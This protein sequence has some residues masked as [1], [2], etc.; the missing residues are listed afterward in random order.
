MEH[1]GHVG[2]DVLDVDVGLKIL[3]VDVGEPAA[4]PPPGGAGLGTP[5]G[6]IRLERERV[7]FIFRSSLSGWLNNLPLTSSSEYSQRSIEETIEKYL[8]ANS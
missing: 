1:D 4:R 2:L 7:N 5:S 6:C 3:D 8:D